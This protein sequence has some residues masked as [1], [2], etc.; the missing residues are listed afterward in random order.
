M[1]ITHFVLIVHLELKFFTNHQN[2][3]SIKVFE[4]RDLEFKV[5]EKMLL[6]IM[7]SLFWAIPIKTDDLTSSGRY[8]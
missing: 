6:F 4:M 7:R 5:A 1:I 8:L 3:V 2:Q